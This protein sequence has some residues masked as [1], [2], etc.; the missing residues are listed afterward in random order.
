MNNKYIGNDDAGRGNDYFDRG[1]ASPQC[2]N[3]KKYV[4]VLSVPYDRRMDHQL[5]E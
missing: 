4:F 1:K 3:R 5:T 2:Q